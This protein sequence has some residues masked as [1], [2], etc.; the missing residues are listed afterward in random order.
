MEFRIAKYTW[1]GLQAGKSARTSVVSS[2]S[3]KEKVEERTGMLLG[4][5]FG[6]EITIKFTKIAG[7][8][9]RVIPSQKRSGDLT[10]I[11]IVQ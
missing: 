6:K 7:G 10:L 8:A 11:S 5:M 1:D 4:G 2:I 9:R 3:R